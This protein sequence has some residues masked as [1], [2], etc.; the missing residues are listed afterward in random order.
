MPLLYKIKLFSKQNYKKYVV[1]QPV[2]TFYQ[3]FY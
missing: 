2:F 3:V 1:F